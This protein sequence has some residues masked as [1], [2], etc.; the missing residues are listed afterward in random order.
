MQYTMIM[1]LMS[2]SLLE[3]RTIIQVIQPPPHYWLLLTLPQ[4]LYARPISQT[5]PQAPPYQDLKFI[6]SIPIQ[7]RV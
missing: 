7:T 2:S 5:A 6:L 1:G 4:L 3:A